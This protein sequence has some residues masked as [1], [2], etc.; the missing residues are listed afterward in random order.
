MSM[1]MN[2]LLGLAGLAYDKNLE[3]HITDIIRKAWE[4]GSIT[5]NIEDAIKWADNFRFP[6]SIGLRDWKELEESNSLIQLC[7]KRHSSIA[8][9]RLSVERVNKV[10]TDA[11]LKSFKGQLD[12]ERLLDIARNGMTIPTASNFYPSC[13]PPKLRRKYL[14][15]QSA[16]NKIIYG[17][18]QKGGLVLILPTE[19]AK[20]IPGIHFSSTHWTTKKDKASGRVL[21]D[22]SNDPDGNALNDRDKEVQM[23][24]KNMWGK[25]EH[26]TIQDL[27]NLIVRIAN[28]S[29]WHNILLWKMDLKGAFGLLR[30]R[31][32]DTAKFAFEL[33]DGLSLIHT[34]GMFGWTGTPFAFSVVSRILE[35]CI[36]SEIHGGLCVYVDDLCGCSSV[37]HANEDQ[38]IAKQICTDLLGEDALAEDKHFQGRRLDML[39]WSFDLD[40]KTVSISEINHLKTIYCMFSI[41]INKKQYI[42]TWQAIASRAS[43]YVMVC[44]HMKPY[45]SAFHRMVSSFNG[46]T[47]IAK[48]INQD[49]LMD[50][51]MWKA[52]LCLLVPHENK[53]ARQLES[54]QIQRATVKIEYDASLTGF[55]YVISEL[56]HNEQWEIISFL[57][58]DF[59]FQQDTKND[60]SF[61]NVCEFIAVISALICLWTL[62]YKHFNYI[63]IGDNISS[64]SWCKKGRS[65]SIYARRAMISFSLLSVQIQATLHSTVHTPGTSN[66]ICDSLSRQEK[67][68]SVTLREDLISPE[69]V[70][71]NIVSI[72]NLI[73]PLLCQHSQIGNAQIWTEILQF[74]QDGHKIRDL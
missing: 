18:Y 4:L 54:F 70:V 24:V 26:P 47:S 72:L 61:Q 64:L 53:F 58:M 74:L 66:I 14:L 36:N 19:E 67:R 25:I 55:G 42:K 60:S 71:L 46:S 39:G 31:S 34:A 1:Q 20:K 8:S 23:A 38:S 11:R 15:V 52:F 13:K 43:R 21:G 37:N 12:K 48:D 59:P 57:G 17:M 28:Q 33:S 10:V 29:G 73:N 65:N 44:E 32:Q 40:L 7:E 9:S 68:S 6:D 62:H 69:S 3:L 49:A 63:L 27:V 30:I 56:Q 41:D 35:G 22:Q 2:F 16:V 5:Y 50:L 45:T 51:E